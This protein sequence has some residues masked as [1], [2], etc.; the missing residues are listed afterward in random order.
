M[1]IEI[2]KRIAS[3][4]AEILQQESMGNGGSLEV[5]KLR[6]A[7]EELERLKG[8]ASQQKNDSITN[9]YREG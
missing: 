4:S 2:E 3:L 6:G 1:M 8:F 9:Q 5:A 7:L